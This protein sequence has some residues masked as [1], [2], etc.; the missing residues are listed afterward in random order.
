MSE[1]DETARALSTSA[2]SPCKLC[3]SATTRQG[4]GAGPH[5]ARL[6]CGGCGR[7]LKWLARPLQA[8]TGERECLPTSFWDCDCEMSEAEAPGRVPR[9]G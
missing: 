1:T 4:P 6:E 3:G 2:S 9:Q 8:K 5:H 7:F